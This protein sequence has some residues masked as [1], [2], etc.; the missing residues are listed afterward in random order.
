MATNLRRMVVLGPSGTINPGG[1]HDYRNASNR[2]FFSDTRTRWARFWADWPTLDPADGQLDTTRLA[3]LDAQIAR[4]K[5]DGLKV[6][7]TLYR[8]PTWANGTATMTA[9][10]L[11][12]TMPDRK[13]AND[14]DTKAKSLLLR[15]PDD[16]SE[17]SRFGRF[18]TTLVSRYS[19]NNARR[20]VLDAVVDFI[21]VGNE[22]NYTWWPQQA[23]SADPANPYA[24]STI[25][26]ADVV[27]HMFVTAQRITA[28]YGGEPMLCGPGT[29]D[30]TDGGRL[31]T[32]YHSFTERLLPALAAAGFTA[33]AK[34][35]WSHHNYTD[36]T[37]DMG[38]GSTFPGAATDPT[39]LTNRAADTR[40]RLV[41][42]W[43]GW[44]AGDPNN[45]Q[46]LLTEGGVTLPNIA[47]RWRITDR[48]A[49]LAKQADLVQRNWNRMAT[50]T[51]DGVGIAMLG[52][53]LW[54]TDP[55]YDCGLAETFETGGATRPAYRTWKGL[56]S[57][58]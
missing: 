55:N 28:R 57:Y 47:A 16:V 17:T 33:G 56:P 2:V 46:I 51:G 45:P 13:G 22:P 23:P 31:R 29:S 14:A 1:S 37:Y 26:I 3:A 49:Q 12:A 48:A 19:R 40:R 50:G 10:Q 25:T 18:L 54:Y 35:A 39:R 20:P 58:Q 32:A 34:F 53:Y 21:E 27:A 4:A 8:F 41:G 11:A 52:Y 24:T 7:L 6:I 42:R 9:E 43:A 38:A 15:Y 36:V 30:T 44:P 5:R